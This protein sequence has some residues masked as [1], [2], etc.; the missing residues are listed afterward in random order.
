MN[1]QKT[2]VAL[3]NSLI[4][5]VRKLRNDSV[6]SNDLNEEQLHYLNEG[7]RQGLCSVALM[8]A[9]EIGARN[10]NSN[11]IESE[12]EWWQNQEFNDNVKESE[13]P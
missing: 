11:K 6:K 1:T 5:Q 13:K 10:G 12:E 2:E 9:D 8:L 7:Y 4:K 3:L